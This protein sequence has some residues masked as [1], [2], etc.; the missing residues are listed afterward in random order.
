[1]EKSD[2]LISD[3]RVQ[4]PNSSNMGNR[5]PSIRRLQSPP[6]ICS[7]VPQCLWV[8]TVGMPR[9]ALPYLSKW[10]VAELKTALGC[11]VQSTE[12]EPSTGH[13]LSTDTGMVSSPTVVKVPS[14]KGQLSLNES[15]VSL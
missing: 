11:S 8:P 7:G 3:R 12:D 10:I 4:I 1:M 9:L 5:S 14:F 6:A 15:S 13:I 2:I